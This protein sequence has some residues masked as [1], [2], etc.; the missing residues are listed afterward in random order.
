MAT[1]PLME[2]VHL[3]DL[4]RLMES[5]HYRD[6][7]PSEPKLRGHYRRTEFPH[8]IALR[9]EDRLPPAPMIRLL[10]IHRDLVLL[11][12]MGSAHLTVLH[13]EHCLIRLRLLMSLL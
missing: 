7:H 2:S 11:H 3:I 5:L 12:P 10:L 8:L 9:Q 1:F 6:L 4:C 13:L